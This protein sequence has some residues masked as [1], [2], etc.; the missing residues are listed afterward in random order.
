MIVDY[1][2]RCL[3]LCSFGSAAQNNLPYPHGQAAALGPG[4]RSVL[5]WFHLISGQNL[6]HKILAGQGAHLEPTLLQQRQELTTVAV[7]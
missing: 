2:E 3:F 5:A 1:K 7:G 4:T 6:I